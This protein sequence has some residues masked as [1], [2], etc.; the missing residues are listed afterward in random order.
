[1]MFSSDPHNRFVGRQLVVF[2]AL[3]INDPKVAYNYARQTFEEN[4]DE[5]V[6]NVES[7][8]QLDCKEIV[9]QAAEEF[10][11]QLEEFENLLKEK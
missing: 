9:E 1:M 6:F 4:P 2:Y 8:G 5:I 10:Q 11:S 3:G 7:W